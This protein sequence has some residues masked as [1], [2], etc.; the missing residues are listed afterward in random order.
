V[1][2]MGCTCS[3]TSTAGHSVTQQGCFDALKCWQP[4]PEKPVKVA[5]TPVMHQ[6]HVEIQCSP[7]D[8]GWCSEV[9][10]ETEHNVDEP[11][12]VA[13]QC[14]PCDAGWSSEVATGTGYELIPRHLW[15]LLPPAI[16]GKRCPPPC[17]G[18]DFQHWNCP[19][20]RQTGIST[21]SF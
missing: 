6:C 7:C 12:D 5:L 20:D 16:P 19:S 8:A 11:K 14:S 4:K 13:T 2:S 9:A 15:P 21:D 10:T 17:T 18:S 3:Y 1:I